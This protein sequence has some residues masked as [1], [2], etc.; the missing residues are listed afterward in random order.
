MK[1][2]HFSKAEKTWNRMEILNMYLHQ[3]SLSNLDHARISSVPY[4]LLS[5]IAEMPM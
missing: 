1:S 2:I 4:E 3:L 5:K